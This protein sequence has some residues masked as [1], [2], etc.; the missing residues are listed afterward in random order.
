MCEAYSQIGFENINVSH[1]ASGAANFFVVA[2][3]GTLIGN[4]K[5]IILTIYIYDH[6]F[7]I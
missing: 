7:F 2:L 6:I 3:G 1:M 4:Q 5:N